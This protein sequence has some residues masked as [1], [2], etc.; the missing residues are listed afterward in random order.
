MAAVYLQIFRIA[1]FFPCN[2]DKKFGY[3]KG[4]NCVL[5]RFLSQHYLN[6]VKG[7]VSQ[8]IWRDEGMGP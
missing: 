2:P 3:Y 1:P 5:V 4:K 8:K 6:Y 7:T